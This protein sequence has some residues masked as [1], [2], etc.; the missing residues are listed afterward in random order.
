[1]A[2]C[3]Y[4][5]KFTIKNTIKKYLNVKGSHYNI[6]RAIVVQNGTFCLLFTFAS[7]FYFGQE[8]YVYIFAQLAVVLL[9][10]QKMHG[11]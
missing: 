6:R 7:K 10:C 9:A 5:V 2:Y 4:F 3:G 8:N 1:M 11:T